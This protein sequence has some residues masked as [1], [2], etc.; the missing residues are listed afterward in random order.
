[1]VLRRRGGGGLV[2]GAVGFSDEGSVLEVV[3][4]GEASDG[5]VVS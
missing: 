1:M 3:G 4:E 5:A 2:R